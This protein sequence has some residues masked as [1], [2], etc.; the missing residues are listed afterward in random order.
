MSINF[1]GVSYLIL[2]KYFLCHIVLLLFGVAVSAFFAD[3][4]KAGIG[5]GGFIGVV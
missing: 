2:C 3:F 1:Y 4:V 5:G